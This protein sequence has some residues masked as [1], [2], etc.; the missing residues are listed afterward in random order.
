MAREDADDA[1]ART[2]D[3]LAAQAAGAGDA[4][5]RGGLAAQAAGA[6]LGLGIENLLVS[7]LADHAAAA[8]ERSQR[9]RQIYGMIDLDG[10]GDGRRPD[11]LR[12]QALVV[13]ADQVGVRR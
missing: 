9:L 13:P 1:L 10:A 3:T 7:H 5:G 4:R 12:L 8:I 6:D 2:D 11:L